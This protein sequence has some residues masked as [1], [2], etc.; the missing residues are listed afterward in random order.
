[1]RAAA[2]SALH[3]AFRCSSSSPVTFALWEWMSHQ[4][5]GRFAGRRAARQI[6]LRL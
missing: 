6:Q 3:A 5:F 2:A 1:M 4:K